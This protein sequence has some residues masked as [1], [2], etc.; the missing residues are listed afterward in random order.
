MENS[1]SPDKKSISHKYNEEM[2]DD[3]CVKDASYLFY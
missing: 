2:S 1:L 3:V